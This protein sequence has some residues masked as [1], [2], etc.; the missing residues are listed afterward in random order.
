MN[1]NLISSI[2]NEKVNL[3]NINENSNP[4]L[5]FIYEDNNYVKF[6]PKINAPPKVNV[7]PKQNKNKNGKLI[8]DKIKKDYKLPLS[9]SLQINED[10]EVIGEN[11]SIK[12]YK[13]GVWSS[14]INQRYGEKRF[15]KINM[16]HLQLSQKNHLMN[17]L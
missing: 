15:Q 11:D 4:E 16:K 8:L 10:I 2:F 5:L 13:N 7:I 9:Y 12:V 1:L 14:I 17:I 6:A 3:R